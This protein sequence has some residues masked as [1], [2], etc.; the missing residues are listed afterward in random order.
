[1]RVIKPVDFQPQLAALL[2]QTYALLKSSNLTVHPSVSRIILHGSRGLA[3]RYRPNSDMDLSLILE[4]PPGSS[5][6]CN[7]ELLREVTE[8]TLGHWQAS[9]E[10]D[11]AVVFDVH[12]C[13]LRCFDQTAWNAQICAKDGIDCF[14]LYKS[15]KGF[16][17]LVSKA[18]VQV[19][20][21]YP[22]L[23]IWQQV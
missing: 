15:Q 8:I 2:P 6:T 10:L 17:G 3:N 16:S 23:K 11:L 21:M 20:L 22:C 1:M 19:K 12:Q 7:I 18:G 5:Q 14:G 4:M 13:Q 9:V